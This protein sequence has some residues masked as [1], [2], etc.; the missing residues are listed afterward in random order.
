MA[1]TFAVTRNHLIFGLC[2]PLAVLLGYMLADLDDPASRVVILVALSVLCVPVL[3]RWYHPLLIL[4]WNAAAQL[5]ALCL[6]LL[7]GPHRQARQAQ[8]CLRSPGWN[9]AR[10]Q[11]LDARRERATDR[12]GRL[13]HV[14]RAGRLAPFSTF[15]SRMLKTVQ[16]PPTSS[17]WVPD[18]LAV[19]IVGGASAI[20][21]ISRRSRR[22][23]QSLRVVASRKGGCHDPPRRNQW[24]NGRRWTRST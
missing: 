24:A 18:W 21:R 7:A 6:C 2:L 22:F 17:T 3:M 11:R 5:A 9:A 14:P 12:A 13:E 8:T 10:H 4:S 15:R 16:L 23:C 1:S 19:R 20:T